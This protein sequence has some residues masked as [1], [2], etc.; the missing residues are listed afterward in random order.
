MSNLFLP[1]GSLVYVMFATGRCG[2]G[3]DNLVAEANQG[4][5]LKMARW[6]RLYMTYLLPVIVLIVFLL[7]L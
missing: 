3:W 1:L 4:K 5:G 7:G 6:M 2:W